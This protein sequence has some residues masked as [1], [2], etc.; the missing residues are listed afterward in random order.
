VWVWCALPILGQLTAVVYVLLAPFIRNT[1]GALRKPLVAF[2]SI[3]ALYVLWI[4]WVSIRHGTP[5]EAIEPTG[6]AVSL[7]ITAVLATWVLR[8]R[9]SVSMQILYKICTVS[10][11]LVTAVLFLAQIG[12]GTDRPG[13][14]MKNPLNLAPVLL[15]P[16]FICTFWSFASSKLWICAGTLSFALT[17]VVMA[18]VLEARSGVIVFLLVGCV[19][20]A[21]ILL[22]N[23]T[24]RLSRLGLI[25][26]SLLAVL[27]VFLSM[28]RDV[29]SRFVAMGELISVPAELAEDSGHNSVLDR[30][31]DHSLNQRVA[32][33]VAGIRAFSEAPLWGHGG[34]NRFSAVSSYL[35]DDFPQ[36]FSHLHNEFLTHAVAGGVPAIVLLFLIIGF[37]LFFAM[38]SPRTSSDGYQI[39]TIFVTAFGGI[40]FFNNVLFNDI[41]AFS[42]GLSYI[43]AILIIEAV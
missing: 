26:V 43:V 20:A 16:A 33:W 9:N 22:G 29:A 17:F 12:F 27:G 5:Q 30:T 7:L 11:L 41:S 25:T 40:A 1:G 39:A 34:Q 4:F 36:D 24:N 10:L 38:R 28:D 18:V 2:T 8:G 19:R 6:D 14:L 15:V 31:S 32:M 3:C 37:P 23:E 35:P 21:W 13:L 42:L